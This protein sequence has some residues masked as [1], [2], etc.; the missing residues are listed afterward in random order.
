MRHIS[1][2]S[3]D[4]E[5]PSFGSTCP[6]DMRRYADRAKNSTTVTWPAVLATDNSGMAPNVS[7]TNV[8]SNYY[9]GRHLVIYNASD[10]AGNYKTCKFYVTVEGK[11]S[12]DRYFRYLKMARTG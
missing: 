1:L 4:V 5:S 10:E 12:K 3:L 2:T 6:S 11:E 8:K 9:K 7:P